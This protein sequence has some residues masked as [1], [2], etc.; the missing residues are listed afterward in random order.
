MTEPIT[1]FIQNTQD[2]RI[3]V[4]TPDSNFLSPYLTVRDSI[5]SVELAGLKKYLNEHKELGSDGKL[6]LLIV[7]LNEKESINTRASFVYDVA[8]TV[9][10]ITNENYF[11]MYA[12]DT[13]L[14]ASLVD[15]LKEKYYV[16]NGTNPTDKNW[17]DTYFPG[18]FWEAFI[19]NLILILILAV[20][21]TCMMEIQTPDKFAVPKGR[22]KVD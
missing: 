7:H 13:A 3:V 5:V 22:N 4:A 16:G 15:Y 1:S 2:N 21:F 14:D 6:D 19:A 10:E 20:G 9:G 18:W 12:A 17:F 8:N 11:G